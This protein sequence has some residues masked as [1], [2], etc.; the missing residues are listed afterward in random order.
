V[1]AW[2]DMAPYYSRTDIRVT[3]TNEMLTSSGGERFTW[4]NTDE[5]GRYW[6]TMYTNGEG[7]MWVDTACGARKSLTEIPGTWD[8]MPGWEHVSS[9]RLSADGRWAVF[10]VR[11]NYDLRTGTPLVDPATT[12]NMPHSIYRVDLSTMEVELVTSMAGTPILGEHGNPDVSDDGNYVAFLTAAEEYGADEATGGSEI[13]R[14]NM[15]N[16][17]QPSWTVVTSGIP[18]R[19][20]GTRVGEFIGSNKRTPIRISGDGTQVGFLATGRYGIQDVS[21]WFETRLYRWTAGGSL[22]LVNADPRN[23]SIGSGIMSRDG[24]AFVT[25][26][27]RVEEGATVCRYYRREVDG[28]ETMI[29]PDEVGGCALFAGE[30]DISHDGRHIVFP[31]EVTFDA[32]PGEPSYRE[33]IHLYTA[34]P[35]A[36]PK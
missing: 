4:P 27:R 8:T 7:I 34:G 21:T 10:N 3:A 33:D 35:V 29:S 5:S 20:E 19:V 1:V 14:V 23:D 15:S 2:H 18:N 30:P 17:D 26:R 6:A 9:P 25:H 13:V 16:T 24:S 28:G 31:N 11:G 32:P 12:T 22:Q 36:A